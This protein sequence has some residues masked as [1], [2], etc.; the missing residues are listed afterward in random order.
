MKFQLQKR[1]KRRSFQFLEL[2]CFKTQK[3]PDYLQ[4]MFQRKKR[5]RKK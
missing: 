1:K 5:K 4:R 2:I 3:V